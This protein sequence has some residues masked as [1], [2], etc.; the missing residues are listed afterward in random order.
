MNIVAIQPTW[1]DLIDSDWISELDDTEFLTPPPACGKGRPNQRRF[2]PV[3][4][5]LSKHF[6][7][8][9]SLP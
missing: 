1:K 4:C 2:T 7:K 3:H 5:L 6:K 8:D 9:L